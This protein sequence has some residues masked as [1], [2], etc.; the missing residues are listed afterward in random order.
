MSIPARSG[1]HRLEYY[2]TDRLNNRS[3]VGSITFTSY[4][5]FNVKDYGARGDGITDDT[6]AIRNAIEAARAH[7]SSTDTPV[8][9]YF[10]AGTYRIKQFKVHS[11]MILK[12]DG[13]QRTKL[14]RFVDRN[15]PNST[16]QGSGNE[17]NITVTTNLFNSGTFEQLPSPLPQD[18]PA[19]GRTGIWAKSFIANYDASR[20][21]NSNIAIYDMT[22]NGN[23]Y[24]FN[25][26]PNRHTQVGFRYA[27]GSNTYTVS[28]YRTKNIRINN[29]RI[30]D[31]MNWSLSCEECEGI[32]VGYLEIDGNTRFGS[33]VS[34]RLNQDGANFKH[35]KH[36]RI[37][38]VVVH[39]S[40]DS[41]V[42]FE[43][44]NRPLP[45]HDVR[46]NYIE[47]H[48]HIH[49]GSGVGIVCGNE[50][51][52]DVYDVH[53]KH[54]RIY[55][56]DTSRTPTGRER[57]SHTSH[58]VDIGYEDYPEFRGRE[59]KGK[60]YN[61]RIDKI[62]ITG[63]SHRILPY[64]FQ[65]GAAKAPEAG[66]PILQINS[67]PRELYY[68]PNSPQTSAW[69]INRV[70]DVT[71]GEVIV[72]YQMQDYAATDQYGAQFG[73]RVIGAENVHIGRFHSMNKSSRGI[74]DVQVLYSS[75]VALHELYIKRVNTGGASLITINNSTGV[76]LDNVR[77]PLLDD[78]QKQGGAALRVEGS[79][80]RDI[81]LRYRELQ[82]RS[83]INWGSD[84]PEANKAT[85]IVQPV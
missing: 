65:T 25:I 30:E 16:Y 8:V 37:D 1:T 12:G 20:N 45:V 70:R 9:V 13:M 24:A 29:L 6:Q 59:G 50:E 82:T 76:L 62:E 44:V 3:N 67:R 83:Q 48:R 4:K 53:I 17:S 57:G 66:M 42:V 49:A 10:P 18:H 69:N 23:G 85:V 81:L 74:S 31:S 14:V 78:G 21:G 68:D 40:Y 19:R 54:I 80:S 28:L 5:V 64:D 72:D 75:N 63:F 79:S 39:E 41:A 36:I 2:A 43:V 71:I 52:G 15:A 34:D 7:T 46:V 58:F 60:A 22:I 77:I 56:R 35:S 73:L 51:G 11:N 61:I 84:V 33:R 27:E 32:D 26:D 55:A 38:R 47:L